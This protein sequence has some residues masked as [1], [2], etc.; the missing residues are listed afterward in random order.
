MPNIWMDIHVGEI[1]SDDYDNRIEKPDYS[2]RRRTIY[3]G[4]PTNPRQLDL[5]DKEPE[6]EDEKET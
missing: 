4:Y 6:E 1:Y 2:Q 3:V 5:F